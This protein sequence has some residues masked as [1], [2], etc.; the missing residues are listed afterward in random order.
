MSPNVSNDIAFYVTIAGKHPLLFMYGFEGKKKKKQFHY[1][2]G[3]ARKPTCHMFTSLHGCV[4]PALCGQHV[5]VCIYV[6]AGICLPS[7]LCASE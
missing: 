1:F 2:F 3:F 6:P 4:C 7:I 5:L